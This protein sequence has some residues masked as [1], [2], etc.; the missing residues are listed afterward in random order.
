MA[1]WELSLPIFVGAFLALVVVIM[2]MGKT[3]KLLRGPRALVNWINGRDRCHAKVK[4]ACHMKKAKKAHRRPKWADRPALRRQWK[5]PRQW[6]RSSAPP[7][8]T[9]SAPS[10]VTT[11]V[12]AMVTPSATPKLVVVPTA[13]PHVSPI[14]SATVLNPVGTTAAL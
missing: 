11:S 6:R 13:A 7:A 5:R 12:P 4:K 9:T 10:A 2:L 3:H 1:L 8:V 14:P